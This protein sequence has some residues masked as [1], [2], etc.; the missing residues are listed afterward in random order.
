ME[1]D[2]AMNELYPRGYLSFPFQRTLSRLNEM[3]RQRFGKNV[4]Q[5]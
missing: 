2:V 1:A 3:Q 5:A 4:L